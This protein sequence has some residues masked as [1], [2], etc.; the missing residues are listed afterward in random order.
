MKTSKENHQLISYKTLMEILGLLLAL[1]GT[2][3][4][5][6]M[7]DLGKLNIWAALLIASTKCTLVVLF[8]MH[9]KYEHRVI[10]LSFVVTLF[11]VAILIGFIFWDIAFR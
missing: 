9:L 3:I 2:T 6:S 5:I 10:K 11:C 7:V 1:T 8:F 4:G